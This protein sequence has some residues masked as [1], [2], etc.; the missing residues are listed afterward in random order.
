ML[1]A[2]ED[3]VQE[4]YAAAIGGGQDGL[5]YSELRRALIQIIGKGINQQELRAVVQTWLG[6]ALDVSVRRYD[7]EALRRY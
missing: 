4:A 7:L 3:E 1:D 6:A 5:S 2:E